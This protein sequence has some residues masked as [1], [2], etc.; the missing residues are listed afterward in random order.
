MNKLNLEGII[1]PIVTPFSS[2][3]SKSLNEPVF[4][5]II[6]Y[7]LD[8]GVHGIFTCGANGEGSYLSSQEFETATK[9]A[10]DH[11]QGKVPIITGV[12]PPDTRTAINLARLAKSVGADAIVILTPHYYHPTKE[13][14]IGHY[15]QVAHAVDIPIMI[16]NLPRY[17]GYDLSPEVVS[18]LANIENV[19]S[20]KDC[21]HDVMK[22][23][24]EI[25]LCRDR[26][27]IMYGGFPFFLPILAMG[28][29]GCITGFSNVLPRMHVD[30][31]NAFKVGDLDKA[32]E[33]YYDILPL[34][35]IGP[36]PV[37]VKAALELL[38]FEVGT[39]R[40]PLL[41]AESST[42]KQLKSILANLKA[43]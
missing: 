7:Q 13:G 37:N 27:S 28:G 32:R 16:Y 35:R 6:D 15:Q 34:V 2:D 3:S 17:A 36:N 20:I 5:E 21:S 10:V 40:Q 41:P 18:E 9:V 38:G 23:A 8:G 4:R 42:K 29:H 12:Q 22:I 1:T 33:I 31:L 24:E 26:I 30:L 25:R 11:V 14:I 39:P 43:L 19:V